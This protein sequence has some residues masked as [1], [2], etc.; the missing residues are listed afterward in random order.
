MIFS[1]GLG[2]YNVLLKPIEK[3]VGP[4]YGTFYTEL[5]ILIFLGFY[6]FSYTVEL[7]RPKSNIWKFLILAGFFQAIG[8]LFFFFGIKYSNVSITSI[9]G[10]SNPLITWIF[11]FAFLRERIEWNQFIGIIVTMVGLIGIGL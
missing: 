8:V 5:L 11:A 6:Y 7:Q 4:I 10:A 3:G 9:I 1:C 2:L